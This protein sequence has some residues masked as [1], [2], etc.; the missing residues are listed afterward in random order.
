MIVL[1][2][3]SAT[4]VAGAAVVNNNIVLAERFVNNRKTHSVNLLPMVKAA[5]EEAAIEP[6]SI[7][8]IA[9]SSGPG[10]FTGIRIGMSTAKTLAQVWGLPVLGVS[11]LDALAYSL[12]GLKNI[13]CPILNA[14]KNEVYTAI[15][16]NQGD[17]QEVVYGPAAVAPQKLV[18]ILNSMGKGVTFLGDGVPEYRD[19]L[20]DSLGGAQFAPAPVLLPRGAAIAGLAAARLRVIPGQSPLELLPR[21]I[22]LSEAENKLLQKQKAGESDAVDYN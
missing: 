14:R 7:A 4:P 12:N 6:G 21:Y 17:S 19:F 9:V 22:R 16:D 8:A 15:Y 18:D 10:S 3:E 2:I 5:I 1:G 20:L 13:V 11:T